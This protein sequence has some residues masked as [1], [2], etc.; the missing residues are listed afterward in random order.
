[1]LTTNLAYTQPNPVDFVTMSVS[2]TPEA[3]GG[4]FNWT[5]SGGIVTVVG[6]PTFTVAGQI[7][8]DNIQSTGGSS[9]KNG[10]FI[11]VRR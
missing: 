7:L 1:M 5:Y 8:I 9:G 6:G 2:D 10:I 3:Q 4:S 11:M